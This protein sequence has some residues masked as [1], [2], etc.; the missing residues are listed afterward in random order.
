MD[1]GQVTHKATQRPAWQTLA[2][3][4]LSGKS[5]VEGAAARQV[6]RLL[7]QLGMPPK[8]VARINTAVAQA[9]Q[10]VIERRGASE[11]PLQLSIRVVG[12]TF[13]GNGAG[14]HLAA[15]RP[16]PAAEPA[17]P[18]SCPDD[19]CWGFFLVGRTAITSMAN[20]GHGD[21][22]IELFIYPEGSQLGE[23]I[24]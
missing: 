18:E 16:K 10:Q 8:A 20:G 4:R 11:L 2:E 22:T 23:T 3:F 17:L 21:Y 5:G 19:Q 13:G 15:G 7:G 14:N 1:E 9:A 12:L 6:A 24:F